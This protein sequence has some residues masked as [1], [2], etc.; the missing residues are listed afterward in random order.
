M[1]GNLPWGEVLS[2][3]VLSHLLERQMSKMIQTPSHSLPSRAFG[4]EIL[5]ELV[6]ELEMEE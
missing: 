3:P 2:S 4:G 6:V 1:C 5:I